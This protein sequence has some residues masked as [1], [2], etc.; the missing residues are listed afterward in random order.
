MGARGPL[1]LPTHLRPVTDRKLADSAA[2]EVPAVAPTKPP[3]VEANAAL[4]D[5]WDQIVPQ[6][7]AAGLVAPSDGTT[8]ELAL[9]HVIVARQAFD[10]LDQGGSVV[11]KDAAIAG[12][13]KKHPAEAVFRSESEMFLKYAQQ[14]GMTFVARARTPSTKG[15]DDG[16]ANPFAAKTVG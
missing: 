6:L 1:K 2:E 3:S 8:I 16:E 13:M 10:E 5:L 12:G 7:D 11:V 14:L 15:A 4:S 9:R